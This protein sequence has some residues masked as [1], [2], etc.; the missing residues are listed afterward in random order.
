MADMYAINWVE[1]AKQ[2]QHVTKYNSPNFGYPDGRGGTNTPEYIIIHHWGS[3]ESTFDGSAGWLCNPASQVS[4][5]LVAEAGRW[6]DL[7]ELSNAAWHA[8]NR[9]YNEHSIGIEC[10][11]RCSQEDMQTVAILVAELWRVYGK[12]PLIGHKDVVSTGCP[13]RW[14]AQLGELTEMAEA[15]YAAGVGNDAPSEPETPAVPKIDE[16]GYWG[17]DTTMGLQ[18]KL[19]MEVQ[20]GVLSNQYKGNLYACINGDYINNNGWDFVGH[21][22]SVGSDTVRALQRMVG[23]SA[24]GVL[25]PATVQALQR[26][27]GVNADGYMGPDTIRALQRWINE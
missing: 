19:G 10:N 8:G 9:W 5:H 18:R 2:L 20:D 1:L 27:L 12:L 11:P 14:Y 6:A 4:A 3:D 15:A 24:D 25:G 7:V 17:K 23:V 13:G 21:V 22:S 26:W 16:D